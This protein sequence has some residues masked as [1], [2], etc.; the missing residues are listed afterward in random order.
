MFQGREGALV[1]PLQNL[2][3]LLSNLPDL[4]GMREDHLFPGNPIGQNPLVY[5]LG[6]LA[7]SRYKYSKESRCLYMNKVVLYNSSTIYIYSNWLT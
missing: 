2:L 3:F 6:T 5:T 1:R 7:R 4:A